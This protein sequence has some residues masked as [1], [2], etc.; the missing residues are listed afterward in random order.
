[1]RKSWELVTIKGSDIFSA[2]KLKEGRMVHKKLFIPGPVEVRQD[3]LEKMA[4]PMIGHRS[5]D[6]SE[7]QHRI[8]DK[9]RKLFYTDE[10]ILLCDKAFAGADTLATSYSL[11]MAIKK[12]GNYDLIICGKQSTDGDTG[13]V[14][15]SLA[16]KLEIPHTTC[17]SEIQEI[18]SSYI[19]CRRMNDE[20]YELIGMPLPA[21]I[22]VVK[23]INE[24]RLASIR[25]IMRA[26]KANIK[27]WSA[28]DINADRLLCGLSG[29][30]TQVIKTFIP[31]HNVKSEIIQGDS[32][33]DKAK[34]LIDK[35]FSVLP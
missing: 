2:I 23:E 25:G 34:K 19:R 4:E 11:S 3:V 33:E 30:P 22:T 21:V 15:P 5:K 16:E 29:S 26:K 17:V 28:D 14:G 18:D 35:L 31:V 7:L 13:Q 8:S 20:G 10:A 27:I 12:I 32:S 9:I 6:A 1:L 24:P